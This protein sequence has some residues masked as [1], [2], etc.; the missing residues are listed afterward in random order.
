MPVKRKTDQSRTSEVGE[1][2]TKPSPKSVEAAAEERSE[3][4][5]TVEIQT[6]ETSREKIM[7]CPSSE[8]KVRGNA[9]RWG[10]SRGE[11][12]LTGS[13]RNEIIWRTVGNREWSEKSE[14]DREFRPC[15]AKTGDYLGRHQR[16]KV[17]TASNVIEVSQNKVRPQEEGRGGRHEEAEQAHRA[18][19]EQSAQQNRHIG[20]R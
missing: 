12:E 14:Q 2:G 3:G 5:P 20:Q 16:S 4:E 10:R 6:G 15:T 11:P 19:I 8:Q 17:D 18:T 1:N 7:D 13:L 9:E